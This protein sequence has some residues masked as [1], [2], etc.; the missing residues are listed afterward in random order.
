MTIPAFVEKYWFHALCQLKIV[1]ISSALH[2]LSATG[3]WSPALINALQLHPM[4]AQ[5]TYENIPAIS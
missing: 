2:R 4:A 1:S 5:F 3:L